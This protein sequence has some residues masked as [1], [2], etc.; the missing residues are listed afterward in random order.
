M[1][2]VNLQFVNLQFG[3]EFPLSNFQIPSLLLVHAVAVF[4][5]K[6]YSDKLRDCLS[7]VPS[8][9][10]LKNSCFVSRHRFSDAASCSKSDWLLAQSASNAKD[11]HQDSMVAVVAVPEA[12]PAVCEQ[13]KRVRTVRM[14]RT[15]RKLGYRVELQADPA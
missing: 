8:T 4:V 1:F 5:H 15:L 13:S 11:Q 12:A 7:G 3:P 6:E 9:V 2:M 10:W 14:I